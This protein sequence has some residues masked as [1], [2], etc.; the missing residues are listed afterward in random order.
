M[1]PPRALSELNVSR[2]MFKRD[3]ARAEC[4]PHDSQVH[5]LQHWVCPRAP[6]FVRGNDVSPL[7]F[8]RF[9]HVFEIIEA[10][11]VS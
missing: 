3:K 2:M 11:A 7:T 10:E 4:M 6:E 9:M 5:R 1:V 8:N